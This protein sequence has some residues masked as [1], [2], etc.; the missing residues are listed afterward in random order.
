PGRRPRAKPR[1]RG[2]ALRLRVRAAARPLL[3]A[4]PRPQG[5]ILQRAVP[6][7]ARGG[8][9]PTKMNWAPATCWALLLA[10]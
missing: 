2:S 6:T 1:R 7:E 5:R 4:R 10:A 3:P 8:F 9:S